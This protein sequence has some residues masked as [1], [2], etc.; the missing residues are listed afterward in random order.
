MDRDASSVLK[1]ELHGRGKG[2]NQDWPPPS[3]SSKTNGKTL[4][5]NETMAGAHPPPPPM[6]QVGWEGKDRL[7]SVNILGSR[8]VAYLGIGRAGHSCAVVMQQA[9]EELVRAGRQRDVVVGAQRDA[10][11]SQDLRGGRVQ[12][13]Y[14]GWVEAA[15]PQERYA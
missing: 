9:V 10:V 13:V 2:K 5:E 8:G 6:A 14:E 4:E 7:P 3:R 11:G 15:L 12:R 1:L